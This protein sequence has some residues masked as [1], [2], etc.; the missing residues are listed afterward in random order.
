M[1][2]DPVYATA[3]MAQFSFSPPAEPVALPGLSKPGTPDTTSNSPPRVEGG[4][5]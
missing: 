1:R 4:E 2:E 5:E 3:M